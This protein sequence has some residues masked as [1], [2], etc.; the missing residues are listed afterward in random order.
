MAGEVRAA[1]DAP[2]RICRWFGFKWHAVRVPHH[3]DNDRVLCKPEQGGKGVS[4]APN[5]DDGCDVRDGDVD[6]LLD[7]RSRGFAHEGA[8]RSSPAK[9]DRSCGTCSA[10]VSAGSVDVRCLRIQTSGVPESIRHLEH[11]EHVRAVRRPGNG[12]DHGNSGGTLH[13]TFCS[14][15]NGPRWK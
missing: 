7:S 8:V 6:N 12:P 2:V 10:D 4:I 1:A 3:T 15:T 9:P 14:W 13:R 5:G 11:T